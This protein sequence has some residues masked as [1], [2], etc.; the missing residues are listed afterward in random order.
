MEVGVCHEGQLLLDYRPGGK[1]GVESLPTLLEK[2]LNRL[3]RHVGRYLRT[4]PPTLKQLYLCGDEAIVKPAIEQFRKQSSLEVCHVRP[5]DVKATWQL[6]E[7]STEDI[8]AAALGALLASYLPDA[9]ADAPNLMQHII[10]RKREPLR[11]VLIRS[12]LPLAATLL[13]AATLGIFNAREE[14]DLIAMRSE[15]ESLSVAQSRATELRLQLVSAKTKLTQLQ[16]IAAQLP[17][18]L[19]NAVVRRL[20]GCMPS[21]VWLNRFEAIDGLTLRL[22]GA[23]YLEA[24]VYDFVRWLEQAPGLAEVALKGTSPSSSATGPITNFELELSLANFNA[25]KNLP[26]LKGGARGGIPDPSTPP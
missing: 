23:S 2:H 24:G 9:D 17:G 26:S 11:P 15:L 8:T 18:E 7:D 4:A 1:T 5:A 10:E 14:N 22:Q 25:P 3:S 12:A 20:A 21:D 6:R 13:I 16:K 19:G